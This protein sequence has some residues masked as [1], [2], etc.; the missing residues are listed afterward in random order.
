MA[1]GELPD[2]IRQ[3][4]SYLDNGVFFN[5]DG[6]KTP[7]EGGIW[8]IKT[9]KYTDMGTFGLWKNDEGD[10]ESV[11]DYIMGVYFPTINDE[12]CMR[13]EQA[14][15]Y[16]FRY[17]RHIGIMKDQ[18]SHIKYFQVLKTESQHIRFLLFL[19]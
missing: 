1:N 19:V 16:L 17:V 9:N 2:N 3:T 6:F 15:A 13:Q 10:F 11:N 8:N 14:K 18:T 4:L 12:V 7:Y 5:V